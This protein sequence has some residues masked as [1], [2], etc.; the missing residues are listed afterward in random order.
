MENRFCITSDEEG[1]RIDL[2][3]A[4]KLS[5]TRTKVKGMI[6]EGLVR[7]EGRPLKPSSK[8]KKGMQLE[9]E[10]PE[11]M[12]LT[13]TPEAIP[14]D[15]LYED[16]HILAVNK[17]DN[18]VVH[19][20]FGHREGTLVN[21]IL[22]YLQGERDEDPVLHPVHPER[23]LAP[24]KAEDVGRGAW[25]TERGTWPRPGIVHRLD[26]GTTGVILIAKDT[27]TQ[28]QLSSLFKERS[29]RKTYRALVEGVMGKDEGVIEG[30]IGRHPVE[31]KKMAVVKDRGREATTG[32]KVI[33]RIAGFTYV[34][35]Y[36]KT[37]RTHQIRVHLAHIGHPVVGDE[38][39]GKKARKSAARPLLHAYGIVFPHP[40][41]GLPVTI[42]A[43]V[44]EDM[45]DFITSHEI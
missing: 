32:Y 28:E 15:I 33:K 19:P 42:S 1:K 11:E 10:I 27:R 26:K 3:L 30:S 39:Y 38:A 12:P 4:E 20:S 7:V 40:V 31:R 9:G 25:N 22:A 17:P 13:L 21:A 8:L 44:P 16:Q 6:E 36:P 37:G 43:P 2:Y 29:V 24:S 23:R 5:I 41:T 14:L 18:M 35:A 34:E 45:E